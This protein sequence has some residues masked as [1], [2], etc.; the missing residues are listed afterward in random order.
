MR[1]SFYSIFISFLLSISFSQ[2]QINLGDV[3]NDGEVNVSDIVLMIQIVLGNFIPSE[4]QENAGDFNGDFV[5]DILDI[6]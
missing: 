2:P 4:S 6:V 5:I 1:D 3:N